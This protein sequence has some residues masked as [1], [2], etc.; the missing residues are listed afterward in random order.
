MDDPFHGAKADIDEMLR[1]GADLAASLRRRGQQDARYTQQSTELQRIVDTLREDLEDVEET[2][3]V[4]GRDPLNF[5]V[6]E[7]EYE[8]RRQFVIQASA[9]IKDLS[10]A[11]KPLANPSASSSH[12]V[13]MPPQSEVEAEQ[14]LVEQDRALH[15]QDEELHELSHAVRRVKDMSS[16]IHTEIDRQDKVLDKMSATVDKVT[17]RLRQT[18]KRIDKVVD[19]MSTTK[20]YLCIILLS[21]VLLVLC[22]LKLT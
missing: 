15:A 1:K 17:D 13:N 2:V 12:A 22:V 14:L 11:T 10:A 19:Q 16:T 18:N 7:E 3:D 20:Q 9:Q 4:V 6:T 8:R 21:V 5:G